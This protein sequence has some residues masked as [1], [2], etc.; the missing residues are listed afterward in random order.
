VPN[1]SF[2]AGSLVLVALVVLMTLS[3]VALGAEG[4]QPTTP[5]KE[6]KV[7]VADVIPW[8]VGNIRGHKMLYNEGWFVVTSSSRAFEYAKKTSIISSKMALQ[9]VASEASKDSGKY[10]EAVLT[11]VRDSADT[12]KAVVATGTKLSGQ[13][14]ETTHRA[15]KTELVY[16][17]DSFQK[18][19]SFFV[20]GNLSI[21]KRTEDER[22]ELANLPGNYFKTLNKDFS[23]IFELADTARQR[24]AGKIDPQW[25]SAF[26]KASNEFRA[27]YEKS[28]KEHNSL[29]ALGPILYGYLKSFYYGIA[30]PTSKTIVK[31]AAVGTSYAIFLPITTT[32]VVAGRTV[33]SV[34]LTIYYVGKTGVKIVSPTVEG[35]LLTGLSLLSVSSVPVTYAAG[36]ALGAVNQVAF[37]TAG[38]VAGAAEGAITTTAHSAAYVGFLAYDAVK[39]TTQVVI[40][41][42]A[43]GIV[44]GYN[45]LTAIPTHA[46]IGVVDTAVFLAWDGPRLVIAAAEGRIGTKN[47]NGASESQ[48]LGDL[49][50]GTIV[51]LKKLEQAEGVKVEVLSTDPVVIRSVIEKIPDDVR[52]PDNDH[53]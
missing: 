27:E 14:L 33:Q 34:G 6:E 46:L 48:S 39:G 26:Q 4:P 37:T 40:N 7:S 45:A 35:G 52:E 8:T 53:R 28:G 43:S 9:R 42:A 10:K 22:Q 20:R 25:E 51:D 30:A 29:M 21:A 23:N 17:Q 36:G 11:D 19:M 44:L 13:I 41:Q 32:S 47:D 5:S 49:P 18:A 2:K 24:F 38:P 1:R 15:A 16:A 31:S 3:P 50:V 12:G